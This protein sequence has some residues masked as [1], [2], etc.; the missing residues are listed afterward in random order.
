MDANGRLAAKQEQP[1]DGGVEPAAT[2]AAIG[3]DGGMEVC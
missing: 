1:A 2:R 3:M